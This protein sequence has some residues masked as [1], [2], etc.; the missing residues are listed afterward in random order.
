MVITGKHEGDLILSSDV[1][2]HG[3][4]CGNLIV[5]NGFLAEVRGMVTDHVTVEQGGTLILRGMA[6]EGITNNGG[7]VEIYGTVNGGVR[8][9]AGTTIVAPGAVV[10]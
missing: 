4:I 5:T 9:I 6:T 2:V 10:N 3:M 8:E 1:I 7:H